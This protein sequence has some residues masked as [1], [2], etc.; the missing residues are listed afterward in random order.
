MADPIIGSNAKK[1]HPFTFNAFAFE[2]LSVGNIVKSLTSS[3]YA[4]D[5][6]TACYAVIQV[7]TY[8]VRVRF[9]GEDPTTSTGLRYLPESE[10]YVLNVNNIRNARFINSTAGQTATLQ[11]Q[12]GK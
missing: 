5:D 4:E 3:V 12:Y 8:G 10:I 2:T 11:I 7:E 1:S 6:T 9:D